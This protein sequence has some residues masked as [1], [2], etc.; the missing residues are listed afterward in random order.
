M[1]RRAI[2][3]RVPTTV[4]AE[5][6]HNSY[7]AQKDRILSLIESQEDMDLAGLEPAT[8]SLRTRRSTN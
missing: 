8:F 2:C 4:Q 5:V 7:E 6:E 3:T 1:K